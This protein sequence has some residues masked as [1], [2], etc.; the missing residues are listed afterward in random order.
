MKER[1]K[2]KE[3]RKKKEKELIRLKNREAKISKLRVTGVTSHPAESD[4]L[5]RRRG[6]GVCRRRI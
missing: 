3:R 1:E 6:S 2:K 5:R 4:R